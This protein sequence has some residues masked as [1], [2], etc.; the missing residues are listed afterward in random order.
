MV[1]LSIIFDENSQWDK[2]VEN[3]EYYTGKPYKVTDDFINGNLT[4]D[5]NKLR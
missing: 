2:K 5:Q 1:R 4:C 3:I